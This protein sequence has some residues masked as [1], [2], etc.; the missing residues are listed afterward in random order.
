[1][2]IKLAALPTA[3]EKN[4]VNERLQSA[5]EYGFD[6]IFI[7]HTPTT[8]FKSDIPLKAANITNLDTGSGK[9]GSL[10]IMNLETR[11]IQQA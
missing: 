3:T 8:Y 10:T 6:E 7:G 1:M 9:G 4:L 5:I 11:E 2:T